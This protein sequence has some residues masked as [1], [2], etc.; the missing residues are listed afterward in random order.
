MDENIAELAPHPW[1]IADHTVER[2]G[3]E[4]GYL[5][6]VDAN[7]N[8]ICD[9]FPFAGEGGRGKAATLALA[10]QIVDWERASIE[11]GERQ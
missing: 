2:H 4:G 5:T 10:Q 8:R 3:V 1:R 6:I 9:F 7:L 11:T